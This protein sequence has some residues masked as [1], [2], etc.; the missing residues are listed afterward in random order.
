[1][2]TTDDELFEELTE[3]AKGY[4]LDLAL[5]AVGLGQVADVADLLGT[6]LDLVT[7]DRS[8]EALEKESRSMGIEYALGVLAGLP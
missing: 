1:M 8:I 2:T 3:L 6:L 7:A 5:T 4:G